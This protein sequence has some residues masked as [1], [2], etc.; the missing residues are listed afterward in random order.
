[1]AVRAGLRVAFSR[2]SSPVTRP[3]RCSG[4]PAIAASGRTT[5]RALSATPTKTSIVPAPIVPRRLVAVPGPS[6]PWASSTMPSTLTAGGAAAQAGGRGA[7]SE[8]TPRIAA[9]GETRVARIAGI[10]AESSV[11][12][13]PTPSEAAIVRGA[14]FISPRGMPKPA[15]SNSAPSPRANPSPSARP[16]AE[17]RAAI[18]SASATTARRICPRVEPSARS[19]ANS[20]ARSAIVIENVLKMM[21]APTSSA[22][23]AKASR[24]GVRKPIA[25][26]ISPASSAA[27]CWPVLMSSVAGSA[28]CRRR[29]SCCGLTPDTADAV[30]SEILPSRWDQR[31]TSSSEAAIIVAPPIDETPARSAMPTIRPGEGPCA[32]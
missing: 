7:R 26:L 19:S 21:N 18:S 16:A 13:M 28:R 31:C 1:M 23:P 25:S 10:S 6:M 2:A 17:A 22:A 27:D 15:A 12:P 29:A 20:R 8:V 24:A 3:R 32:S 4:Q 30:I 14:R 9:T 11:T 5:K